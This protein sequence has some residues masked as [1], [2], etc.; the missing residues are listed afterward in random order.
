MGL[1]STYEQ[2]LD[3][4]STMSKDIHKLTKIIYEQQKQIHTLTQCVDQIYDICIY[5]SVKKNE[6]S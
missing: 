4:M 2:F 3:C 5:E 1:L 6:E